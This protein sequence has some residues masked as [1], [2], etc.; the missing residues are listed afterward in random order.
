MKNHYYLYIHNYQIFWDVVPS[1]LSENLLRETSSKQ[2]LI[3]NVSRVCA[4]VKH[5]FLDSLDIVLNQIRCLSNFYR[6]FFE[7]DG[8]LNINDHG[9]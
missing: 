5:V 7:N 8:I 3:G 2:G 6:A 9:I 4:G 1:S